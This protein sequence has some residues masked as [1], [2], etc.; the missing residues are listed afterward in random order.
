MVANEVPTPRP[1]QRSAVSEFLVAVGLNLPSD[2]VTGEEAFMY[3]L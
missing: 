2:D 3:M 1:I